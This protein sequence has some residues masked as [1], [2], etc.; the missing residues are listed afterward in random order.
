[1]RTI[2]TS[3]IWQLFLAIAFLTMQSASAHIHLASSHNHD[4]A[5]HSHAQVAHSH[6]VASHHADAF[7]QNSHTNQ[8]VEL[9]QDWI[10]K[11][12]K[13]LN[14]LEPQAVL[15][16][17][18]SCDEQKNVTQFYFDKSFAYRSFHF[19]SNVKARAPPKLFPSLV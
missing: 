7:D 18:F 8:V 15:V 17:S 2:L 10:V 5:G 1:M 14:D 3:K 4:G 19:R 11:Y 12:V 6:N 16:T 13:W 9:S